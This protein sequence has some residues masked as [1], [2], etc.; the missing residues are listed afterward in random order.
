MNM[1]RV[2]RKSISS[3][4]LATRLLDSPHPHHFL[5]FNIFHFIRSLP[6]RICGLSL[7]LAFLLF[8][9]R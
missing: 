1:G 3:W 6:T 8:H 4:Q 7:K 5:S 2:R 9:S